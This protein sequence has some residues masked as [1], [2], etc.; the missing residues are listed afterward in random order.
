MAKSFSDKL[1]D[2]E[3]L[4]GTLI[5][6]PSPRWPEN[7]AKLGLDFVFIDTEH[8]ALGRE[9]LSWMCQTY[10]AL[11][12]PPI[13][14]IISPDPYLACAALDGG[15]SGIIAPYV[16]SEDQVRELVGAVKRRPLKGEKLKNALNGKTRVGSVLENYMEKAASQNTLIVNIESEAGIDRNNRVYT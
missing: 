5:V 6:S 7:I 9:T 11:G 8:I 4:Y 1:R 15:A 13:V 2:G 14:R 3:K 16:E 12:L 10:K